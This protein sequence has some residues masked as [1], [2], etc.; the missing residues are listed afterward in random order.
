M[1]KGPQ[2]Q[3]V[4]RS[5]RMR[6]FV[7]KYIGLAIALVLM[8]FFLRNVDYVGVVDAIAAARQGMI[9]L[10]F[11]LLTLGYVIRAIRWRYLL[12]PLGQVALRIALH[13][14]MIGFAVNSILP[15]RVGELL[16]PYLLARQEGL[17]ASAVVATVLVERVLDLVAILLIFGISV[18]IFDPG[19]VG[20]NESII[21]GLSTG[22]SVAAVI[23]V[24]MLGF[25]S[26]AAS[27]P[28]FVNRLS[29][30]LLTP[31]PTRM[32]EPLIRVSR[33]FLEGFAVMRQIR[34]LVLSVLWSIALW[35]SI[36]LSLW[37][38]TVA[39]DIEMPAVGAGVVVVLIAVGVAVPT[40]A[41]VGG[42]HAAYQLGV[43]GL[44]GA[45]DAAAVGAG[46]VAHV[47][48]FL[49]VTL[50]GLVLMARDGLKL[51]RVSDV[52]GKSETEGH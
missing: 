19:F 14:T 35:F 23:A 50:I 44:Y 24:A 52:V 18:V 22:A 7:Q 40:P 49:P 42:Y 47:L 28:A 51:S 26:I 48:S 13:S 2:D 12:S 36:C 43:T 31:L 27:R 1:T 20:A 21:V 37:L 11:L 29:C 9:F 39:F 38:V 4:V 6:T 34:P 46:L 5:M 3:N 33:R 30:V 25:A 16:R 15:G 10:A 8:I 32:S 45:S 17:S 41:S